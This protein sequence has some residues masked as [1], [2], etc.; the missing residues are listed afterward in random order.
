M[1][2]TNLLCF[3]L[4]WSPRGNARP[5]WI[6]ESAALLQKN[7]KTAQEQTC[8]L[9]L[10]WKLELSYCLPAKNHYSHPRLPP[11]PSSPLRFCTPPTLLPSLLSNCTSVLTLWHKCVAQVLWL[12][13]RWVWVSYPS[14]CTSWHLSFSTC[15][16]QPTLTTRRG[17]RSDTREAAA[18][19]YSGTSDKGDVPVMAHQEVTPRSEQTENVS[20]IKI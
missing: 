15:R 11:P 14:V 18:R 3:L 17:R 2:T 10:K 7:I 5:S 8:P 9:G 12:V 16:Q 6:S 19:L 13:Q 4:Q 1:K 20:V